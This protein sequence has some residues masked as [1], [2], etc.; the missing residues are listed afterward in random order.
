MNSRYVRY[1]TVPRRE[2]FRKQSLFLASLALASGQTALTPRPPPAPCTHRA[3]LLLQAH[4]GNRL[5]RLKPRLRNKGLRASQKE[6]RMFL[7]TRGSLQTE[8]TGM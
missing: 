1:P 5:A 7:D 3:L 8:M 4:C 2:G 6:W